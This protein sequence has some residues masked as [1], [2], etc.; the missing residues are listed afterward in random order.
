VQYG[1]AAIL[2]H[3]SASWICW[4]AIFLLLRFGMESHV[5]AF[6]NRLPFGAS[7]TAKSESSELLATALL[8]WLANKTLTPLRAVMTLACTPRFAVWLHKRWPRWFSLPTEPSAE[9]SPPVAAVEVPLL[10]EHRT[11]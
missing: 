10:A 4:L 5:E 7:F 8:A 3:M 9:P 11:S 1:K 2:L 6:L